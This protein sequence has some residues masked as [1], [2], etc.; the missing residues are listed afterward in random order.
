[1]YKIEN[2]DIS[3]KAENSFEDEVNENKTE[4]VEE[5]FEP[6]EVNKAGSEALEEGTHGLNKMF[7]VLGYCIPNALR[8]Q[9][10]LSTIQALWPLK[11]FFEIKYLTMTEVSKA[12]NRSVTLREEICLVIVKLQFIACTK[13][14]TR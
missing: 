8:K 10:F 9:T 4:N 11:I 14:K 2:A 12:G 5:P 13:N 7:A 6:V 1:M 3:E